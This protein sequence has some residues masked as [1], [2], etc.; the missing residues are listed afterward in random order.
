MSTIEF[1]DEAKALMKL[2][3]KNSKM[4]VF[5]IEIP[6]AKKA[7]IPNRKGLQKL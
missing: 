3:K 2:K 4:R 6:Y 1:V 7:L 5:M